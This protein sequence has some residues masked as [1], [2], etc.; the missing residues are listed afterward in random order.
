MLS[1]SLEPT[2]AHGKLGA[3]RTSQRLALACLALALGA[4][5]LGAPL[6]PAWALADDNVRIDAPTPGSSVSG[7]VEIRGTATTADPARFSFYRL[8]YGAGQAPS[9]LRPIGDAGTQPVVNG[10]LG[11]WDTTPLISGDYSIFLTVYDTAGKTT[12]SQVVVTIVPAPTPTLRTDQAPLVIVTPG[13]T[14]ETDE[15]G[16]TPTPIPELPQ[17]VPQI[18]QIDVPPPDSGA[19]PI[20]PVNPQQTDPNFQPIPITGPNPG[21]QPALPPPAFGPAPQPG[22]FPTFDTSS[23]PGSAPPPAINPVGPPPV[24]I[25][26]PYEPPPPAPTIVPPT[27]E[28]LPP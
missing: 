15:G 1:H 16:P 6:L 11:T 21:N 12:M 28:G 27:Q 3:M 10:L 20:Q 9:T 4:A 13:P 19:A 5:L 23:A 18:P 7:R 17:L 25:V 2:R 22:T 8:H 24:P 26:A 14:S